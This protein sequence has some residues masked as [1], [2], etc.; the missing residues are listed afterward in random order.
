MS[1]DLF[2]LDG[3]FW[4]L[5]VRNDNEDRIGSSYKGDI[6]FYDES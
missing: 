3:W 5:K 1:Q 6:S 4:R 2:W